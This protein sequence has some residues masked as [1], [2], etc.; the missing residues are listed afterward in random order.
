MF[1]GLVEMTAE[2]VGRKRAGKAGKLM[3]RMHR[4]FPEPVLGESVAVNGCCLTLESAAG[5]VFTFHTLA[6]TLDK[7]NLE[8]IV[9]GGLVNIERAMKVGGRLGGHIVSGHIDA[10]GRVL[11]WDRT[12]S[13]VVLTVSMGPELRPFMVDKGSVAVD[14]VS[15]TVVKVGEDDFSVA[16][17]PTTLAETALRVRR[18]GDA[19][20]LETDLVGKYVYRQLMLAGRLPERG[21]TMDTL[22][23][24]GFL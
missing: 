1:T 7:T 15:L 2:L 3:L 10:T 11:G 24:A 12:G 21:V 20:N 6:E 13:D 8:L 9:P 14:G 16:L 18:V 19:V 23:R 22:E 17:I 5:G 4:D